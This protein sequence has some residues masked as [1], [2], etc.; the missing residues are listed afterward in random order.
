MKTGGRKLSII[1]EAWRAV[2]G[3]DEVPVSGTRTDREGVCGEDERSMSI[4]R[5]LGKHDGEQRCGSRSTRML[6]KSTAQSSAR[7]MQRTA[8]HGGVLGGRET[9]MGRRVG[10][11]GGGAWEKQ[12]PCRS[13]ETW[14]AGN[15][16]YEHTGGGSRDPAAPWSRTERLR[17]PSFPLQKLPS[18]VRCQSQPTRAIS[19]SLSWRAS[20]SYVPYS[21]VAVIGGSQGRPKGPKDGLFGKQSGRFLS[22][23]GSCFPRTGFF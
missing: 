16:E 17:A 3:W 20:Q 22:T 14:M 6:E 19:S 9:W 12:A 8:L 4:D 23:A 2:V 5:L 18:R 21:A 1:S 13:W 7:W 11:R 10:D 15:V